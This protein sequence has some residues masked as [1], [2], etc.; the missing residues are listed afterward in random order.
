[1]DELRYLRDVA[2]DP[3]LENAQRKFK[4]GLKKLRKKLKKGT[5]KAS[6][7][8]IKREWQRNISGNAIV[9]YQQFDPQLA[10]VIIVSVRPKHLGGDV[11]I[12][13][14]QHTAMM[15][16]LGEC[17]YLH[18][19]LELH[20]DENASLE[21]VEAAEAS[22]YKA[23]N[24]Q[25][26]KLS[27]LDIIRVDLFLNE[28][29]AMLFNNILNMC[30][31][32]VDGLGDCSGDVVP[33]TGSRF[34]KTVEDYGENFSSY[35]VKAVS[36]MR[37]TWGSDDNPLKDIRDDMIHGLTTLFVFLDESGNIEGGREH[38]LNGKRKNILQWMH[39]EMGNTS[40][41]KYHWNTAGGLVNFKIVYKII[42]EYN[43]W[44]EENSSTLTIS[45]DYLHENG[46]LDPLKMMTTKERRQLPSFPN[47]I[48]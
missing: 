45:R 26:K 7:L 24:T 36:F 35:I 25:N 15:D 2:N 33:G 34:I 10:T 42:E 37:D 20:H 43:F 16:I 31:L 21:E 22:L 12:I 9:K 14:G 28:P 23:L 3:A 19:T 39:S 32:N 1:M 30:R 48:K 27:K 17:D 5:R 6:E 29:Y 11:L 18:D 40:M 8:K 47:D 41:R 44:A 38:G 4:K 46:I 13:D